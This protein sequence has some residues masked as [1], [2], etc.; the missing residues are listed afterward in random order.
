MPI[1]TRRNFT[2]TFHHDTYSALQSKI[3]GI[4]LSSKSAF[5]TGSGSGIGRA[6]AIAFAKAGARAVFLS[7]RTASTLAE[8]KEMIKRVN[9]DTAVQEFVFDISSK[10]GEV[11]VVF[12]EATKLNGGTPIDI[13][14]NRYARA[15][16]ELHA[17]DVLDNAADL[18]SIPTVAEPNVDLESSTANF[19]RYWR[20]FE[21][22]VRGSLALAT[23]FLRHASPTGGTILNL[24]SGAAVIDFVPGLSGYGASKLAALKMFTYLWHEHRESGRDLKVFHIHPGVVATSMA[25]EG[26]SRTEDTAELAADFSVWLLGGDA[27]FLQNRFLYRFTTIMPALAHRLH[28]QS[29]FYLLPGANMCRDV[30]EL[31]D[32]KDRIVEENLLTVGLRGWDSTALSF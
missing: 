1:I 22:N 2:K 24:T 18:A 12:E 15:L 11:D 25:K 9:P 32:M 5:I 10:L 27:D 8:T 13:F 30:D 28:P 23:A 19:E 16:P 26:K 21:V 14:V 17:A 4:S 7:G 20:H 29:D 6:T 3:G 31:V